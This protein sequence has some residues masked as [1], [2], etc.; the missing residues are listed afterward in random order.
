MCGEVESEEKVLLN[1]IIYMD[2]EEDGR[3]IG[4]GES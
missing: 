2:V 4:F 3:E 1:C